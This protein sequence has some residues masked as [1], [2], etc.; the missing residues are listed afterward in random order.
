MKILGGL[1]EC[2]VDTLS[3]RVLLILRRK[4]GTSKRSSL[5]INSSR[6]NH[7][8]ASIFMN[9][10]MIN[11]GTLCRQVFILKKLKTLLKLGTNFE[12]FVGIL[13]HLH[14]L[15]YL[16]T[17]KVKTHGSIGLGLPPD[18]SSLFSGEK[19]SIRL[20]LI[21]RELAEFEGWIIL[22]YKRN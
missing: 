6:E 17:Q 2:N 8:R 1:T 11:W 5:I 19:G 9:T 7:S 3:G 16:P 22:W 4:T 18:T 12:R 21:K 15:K 10:G 13:S 20:K 14:H